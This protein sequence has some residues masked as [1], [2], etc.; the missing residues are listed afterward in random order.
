[1]HFT[2][3]VRGLRIHQ[4]PDRKS[5]C[6]HDGVFGSLA[7]AMAG[8]EPPQRSM[9]WLGK[10][11]RVAEEGEVALFVG[12]LPFF[13]AY[14]GEDLGIE[15]ASSA[16]AAMRILNHLGIE[17]VV[18]KDERCCGHDQLWS[19][20]VDTLRGPGPGQR[21]EPSPRAGSSTS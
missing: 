10:G 8:P 15:T 13:D 3:F 2:E 4:A 18:L 19:G 9:E 14:F 6:P 5:P 16:R 7:R 1:M 11:L 21:R 20:E 12:C 17:P